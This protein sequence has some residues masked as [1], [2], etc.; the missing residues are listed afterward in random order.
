MSKLEQDEYVLSGVGIDEE[1]NEYSSVSEFWDLIDERTWY[2]SCNKYWQCK[3]STNN[4]ML[5]RFEQKIHKIDVKFSITI[6]KF[7]SSEM[8]SFFFV[9]KQNG[10]TKP[11]KQK[12]MK[13]NCLGNI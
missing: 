12:K 13:E 9:K 2:Q 4:D 7:V 10:K 11:K 1:E 5:G 3:K 6:L 8:L